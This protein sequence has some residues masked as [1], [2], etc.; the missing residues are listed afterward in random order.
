LPRPP[1]AHGTI[2]AK[3]PIDEIKWCRQAALSAFEKPRSSPRAGFFFEPFHII[4]DQSSLGVFELPSFGSVEAKIFGRPTLL[5]F[6]KS[7]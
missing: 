5:L 3:I 2:K 6:L 1:A 7:L 4:A